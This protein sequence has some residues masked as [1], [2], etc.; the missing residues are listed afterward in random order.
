MDL[1][2]QLKDLKHHAYLL[3]GN[4]SIRAELLGVLEKTF[5]IATRG[6]PDFTDRKYENFTIDDSRELKSAAEL[7]PVI[8][9]GK[10]IFIVTMNGITV[11]AQN[12]LL[13]LLEEPAE[14]VHFFL[15]VP[16]VHLL[17][18]TVKSRLS[19]ISDGDGRESSTLIEA[20]KFIAMLP[21]KR[22]E[23]I[24]SL[25]DDITKEKKTKQD[26][27]DFLN[28]LQTVV[29]ESKGPKNGKLELESIEKARTYMNDRAPSLKMLLEYV[30]LNI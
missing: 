7:M 26:A 17:L 20:K 23:M 9:G 24:K 13:K 6:N 22:L 18:P 11:E 16:S 28:D 12:A 5:K 3:I 15:I 19:M 14:Y 21:P 8:P 25:M 1:R 4:E 27:I 30:A 10:R 2:A 29:Y